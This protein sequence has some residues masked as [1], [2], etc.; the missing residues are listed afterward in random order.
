[1]KKRT[2]ISIII[3]VL[4]V[5]CCN[6]VWLNFKPMTVDLDIIG[7]GKCSIEAQ[8]NKENN[9]E[10]KKIKSLDKKINLD[11]DTHVN[12]NVERA[13]FPKRIRLVF[14]NLNSPVEIKNITLK[15]GKYKIDDL[16]K[17]NSPPPIKKLRNFNIQ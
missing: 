13:K 3:T 9:N 14:K 1:M 17:F 8:L 10:F 4:T 16:S 15:N 12:I 5:F 2:L 6:K 11:E 7:K